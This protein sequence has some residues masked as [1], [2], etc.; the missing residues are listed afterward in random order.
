MWAGV[1][2]LYEEAETRRVGLGDTTRFG[3]DTEYYSLISILIL[4]V[5]KIS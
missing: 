1:Q 4:Y 5:V 2:E 3:S